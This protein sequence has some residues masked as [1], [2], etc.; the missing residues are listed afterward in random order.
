MGE[1][2]AEEV[3]RRGGQTDFIVNRSGLIGVSLEGLEETKAWKQIKCL[4]AHV[5]DALVRGCGKN[6]VG[7]A[8]LDALAE[9]GFAHDGIDGCEVEC[10]GKKAAPTGLKE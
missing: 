5:A 6:P 3:R 8:V 2:V 4:H 7:A 10:I 9:D 1:R